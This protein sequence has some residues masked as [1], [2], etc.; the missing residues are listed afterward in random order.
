M[1][2]LN[3]HLNNTFKKKFLPILCLIDNTLY[4]SYYINVYIMSDRPI[5]AR[6]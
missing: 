6:H 4:G 3:T 5:K 2:L 1:E